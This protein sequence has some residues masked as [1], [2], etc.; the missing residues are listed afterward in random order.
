MSKF[1]TGRASGTTLVLLLACVGMVFAQHPPAGRGGG[2]QGRGGAAPAAV[3][4]V[5]VGL[6]AGPCD[7]QKVDPAAADRGRGLYAAECVNC[8]GALARGTDLGANLVRSL[9]VL[10]DRVGTE[11]G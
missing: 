8:H 2:G 11:L 10:R 9:I 1:I 3:G 4:C 6:G 7:M 5:P